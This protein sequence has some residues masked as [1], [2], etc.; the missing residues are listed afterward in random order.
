MTSSLAF[1]EITTIVPTSIEAKFKKD[2]AKEIQSE[3]TSYN[4]E[5]EDNALSGDFIAPPK[6]LSAKTLYTDSKCL[7]N[8]ET[9]TKIIE[10]LQ[11]GPVSQST[12]DKINTNQSE[13]YYKQYIPP[14][15]STTTPDNGDLS[16][17]SI[18]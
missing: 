2:H 16:K 10:S 3:L 18:I 4:D 8:T 13:N 17:R 12:Y 6:P 7:L 9:P 1:S 5:S 15:N 14:Y 11:D